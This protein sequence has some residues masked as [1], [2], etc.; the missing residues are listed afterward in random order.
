MPEVLWKAYIDF[1]I[2]EGE[3]ANAREL[4]CR[5]VCVSVCVHT[6]I[7]TYMCIGA[8]ARELHCR[9]RCMCVC[10]CVCVR[11]CV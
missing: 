4:Y 2:A 10:V 5:Y 7:H 9:F 8:N 1:E 3:H 11:A 6:S